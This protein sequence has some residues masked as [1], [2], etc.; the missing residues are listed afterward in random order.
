MLRILVIE[1]DPEAASYLV[2]G[3]SE[4]G[5]TADH[6]ADGQSGLEMALH[7]S[8]DILIVDRMLPRLDGLSIIQELRQEDNLTP[9]LILSALG[10]VDDRVAVDRKAFGVDRERINEPLP[11][12]QDG[13]QMHHR[14]GTI[15]ERAE[16]P[17]ERRAQSKQMRTRDEE[18]LN[19]EQVRIVEVLRERMSTFLGQ[20]APED[21]VQTRRSHW[22]ARQ[23]AATLKGSVLE[24]PCG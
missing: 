11:P 4:L 1:D 22:V 23:H 10:Q 15:G 2:K 8:Y 17:E 6:A 14:L 20:V 5:H 7:S 18:D 24:M 13:N 12:S 9:V 3:L 19:Q 21:G 16:D